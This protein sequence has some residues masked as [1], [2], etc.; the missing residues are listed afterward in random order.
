MDRGN[1][2]HVMCNTAFDE[3]TEYMME[4]EDKWQNKC[5]EDLEEF[6]DEMIEMVFNS[7]FF[8][9]N[10]SCIDYVSVHDIFNIVDYAIEKLDE[11]PWNETYTV[12]Q[13]FNLAWYNVGTELIHERWQDCLNYHADRSILP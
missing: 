4:N 6:K 12:R 10:Q 8:T 11:S 13:S 1:W 7:D 2:Y 5:D 3:I 9:T